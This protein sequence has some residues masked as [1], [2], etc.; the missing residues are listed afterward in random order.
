MPTILQLEVTK[1]CNNAC[2][3]CH[4]GQVSP[5]QDFNRSDISDIVLEQVKP[6]FPYLKHAMLFGDGEPILYKGFWDI[7]S[8]IRSESPDCC[9]DFI[10]NGSLMNKTNVKR[11]FDY[12]VSAMSL[13][14]GGA[15]AATHEYI[16][17]LS[18]FDRVVSNFRYLQAEKKRR[19]ILE[20][21]VSS[22]IVVMR[23]NYKELPQFVELCNDLGFINVGFQQLFVTH[24]SM[25]EEE[26]DS[27]EVEPVFEESS[28]IAKEC[29]IGLHHYPLSSKRV[30]NVQCDSVRF[31]LLDRYHQTK[32]MGAMGTEDGK[33]G[34]CLFEQPWNTVYV[35]HDGHIVPD[36]HWWQSSRKSHLNYC[37]QLN[38]NTDI[39]DIWNGSKYQEIRH[40]IAHGVILPQCRGC[41]LAGGVKDEFCG[42]ETNHTFPNESGFVQ[43]GT[44]SPRQKDIVSEID[45]FSTTTKEKEIMRS[46]FL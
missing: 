43:V 2:I 5:G 11:C 6:I 12:E 23:S 19:G 28:K 17:R 26:M 30:Y 8:D 16:R 45:K 25:K 39:L 14:M 40:S 32:V 24:P 29:G 34:Y 13:S 35:L 18:N 3:M 15:T 22:A 46:I 10:N 7:I 31:N 27:E 42:P 4:K 20:P 36:C 21:Y 38:A 33:R 9:I 41:G 44:S 37:G 1:N